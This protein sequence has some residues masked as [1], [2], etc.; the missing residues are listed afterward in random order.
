MHRFPWLRLGRSASKR[1]QCSELVV[2]RGELEGDLAMF[3]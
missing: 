2:G 3:N 1:D